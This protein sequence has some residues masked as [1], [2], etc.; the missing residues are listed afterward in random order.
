MTR[1]RRLFIANRGEVAA[2]IARTCDALGITPVFGVSDAD[3]TAPYL[4]D[5]EFVVL[6]AARA[7]ESYLARERVVQA[8]VQARCSVLHPGWGFLSEDPLF[9]ALCEAH[10]I[11]FIGPPASVMQKLGRKTPAKKAMARAGLKLIPGS[12]GVLDGPG[13]AE[14]I[15]KTVGLPVLLKAESGGG[16]RG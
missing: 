2:R 11:S 3:Q 13:E 5:R 12:D 10:G 1:F 4:R 14:S 6:G 9:A 8:A 16:G 7:S 15:L